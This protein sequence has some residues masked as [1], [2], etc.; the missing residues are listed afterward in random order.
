MDKIPLEIMWKEHKRNKAIWKVK[1]PE[2]TLSFDTKKEAT[3]WAKAL[4]EGRYVQRYGVVDS[5]SVLLFEYYNK[6]DADEL[7]KEWNKEWEEEFGE[8]DEFRIMRGYEILKEK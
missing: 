1:F 4:Q 8:I 3:K 7:V 6:K 2:F 5:K